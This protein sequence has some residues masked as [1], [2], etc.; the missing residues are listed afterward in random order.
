[1]TP[2]NGF[3]DGVCKKIDP[4]SPIAEPRGETEENFFRRVR[5]L[6]DPLLARS[7]EQQTSLESAEAAK[8]AR[9]MEDSRGKEFTFA[10]VDEVFRSR[11]PH[12]EAKRWR[13][14]LKDLGIPRYL[15]G[16]E[17]LLLWSGAFGSR[18]LPRFTMKSVEERMRKES[19][20]VILPGETEPLR[21]YLETRRSEGFRLNLNHLGEA[22]L[23]EAEAGRRLDVVLGLLA[24]PAVDYLSVKISAIFSQIHLVAWD[25][26]R[27]EIQS[28]LRVLYRAA[29]SLGKFVN[30]DME[31]YRDLALTTTAFR[32]VLD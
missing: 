7:L 6:A 32:G 19:A 14:L 5:S 4:P 10:M 8:L 23:G 1:M 16:V 22:V 25:S 18:I 11:C 21:R 20:R 17:R 29:Q 12:V 15:T 31:E 24:D 26:T 2:S 27:I 9:L 3:S 13:Q 28:R 30:L